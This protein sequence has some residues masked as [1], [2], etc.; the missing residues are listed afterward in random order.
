MATAH[1]RHSPVQGKKK[2]KDTVVRE[3]EKRGGGGGLQISCGVMFRGGKVLG[4][5]YKMT[6][7]SCKV[8][9]ISV[10]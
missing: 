5:E 6:G 1:A 3:T 8:E 9:A 4:F 7:V 10:K 2:G